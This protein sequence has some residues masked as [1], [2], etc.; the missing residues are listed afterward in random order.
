MKH[1]NI[2][3]MVSGMVLSLLV[4]TTV[5]ATSSNNKAYTT[6]HPSNSGNYVENPKP[7][8]VANKNLDISKFLTKDDIT[9]LCD[10]NQLK[11]SDSK[12]ESIKLKTWGTHMLEDDQN[13]KDIELQTDPD[14]MVWVVVTSYPSGLDTKAGFYDNAT[15]TVVLD[16]QTGTFMKSMVKGVHNRNLDKK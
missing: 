6:V 8:N 2:K 10:K 11:E 13:N 14:H 7:V 4:A 12:I 15:V 5:L 3:I 9:K 16:A 1:K